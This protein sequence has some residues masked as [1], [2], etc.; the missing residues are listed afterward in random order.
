MTS[1]HHNTPSP[2]L[3]DSV[4]LNARRGD[5]F[6]DYIVLFILY[7]PF[8]VKYM[9]GIWRGRA[10]KG[11]GNGGNATMDQHQFVQVSNA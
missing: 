5:N 7:F 4:D 6:A 1:R 9:H 2:D 8:N 10:H 11:D 3:S